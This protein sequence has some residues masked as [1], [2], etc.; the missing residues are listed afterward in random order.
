MDMQAKAPSSP[1]SP[2]CC[3][4]EEKSKVKSKQV[5]TV[6][7]D[8]QI[9][10]FV[11]Q[12]GVSKISELKVNNRTTRQIR[13]RYKNYLDPNISKDNFSREEDRI[14]LSIVEN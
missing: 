7:E 9:I 12:N 2:C 14:L 1:E 8:L 11:Q 6:D 13:D 3:Q 4:F 10:E 5:F